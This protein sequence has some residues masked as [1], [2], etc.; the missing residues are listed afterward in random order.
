MQLITFCC[1]IHSQQLLWQP[2]NASPAML[3]QGSRLCFDT[4]TKFLSA[5]QF[6]ACLVNVLLS[7][8]MTLPVGMAALS[9]WKEHRHS[10]LQICPSGRAST[11]GCPQSRGCPEEA[12]CALHGVPSSGVPDHRGVD[13]FR[14]WRS[15]SA[16]CSSGQLVTPLSCIMPRCKKH[17]M[18]SLVQL[19]VVQTSDVMDAKK[20][21]TKHVKEHDAVGH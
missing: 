6:A 13:V 5:C 4:K 11:A 16:S 1:C 10:R 19:H 2:P 7:Q 12:E 21:K 14:A 17:A 3:M 18:Q 15:P 20:P 8:S 9:G